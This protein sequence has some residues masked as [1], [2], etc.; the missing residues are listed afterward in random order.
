MIIVIGNNSLTLYDW[1]RGSPC[2]CPGKSCLI[3]NNSNISPGWQP[4]D[5]SLVYRYICQQQQH[6]IVVS[7][8]NLTSRPMFEIII[9]YIM[10]FQTNTTQFILE[11]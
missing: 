8:G 4:A 9:V 7:S 11:V 2:V 10:L 1:A 5:C 6:Q 3:Y